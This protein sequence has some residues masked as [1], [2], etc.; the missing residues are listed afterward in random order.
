MCFVFL[1]S[2]FLSILNHTI[3]RSMLK[4]ARECDIVMCSARRVL[5]VYI[6]IS[7]ILHKLRFTNS[8]I[9]LYYMTTTTRL[10][11][12][13]YYILYILAI[14]NISLSLSKLVFSI[15]IFLRVY[16][17]LN[18]ACIGNIYETESSHLQFVYA[19]DCEFEHMCFFFHIFLS[20]CI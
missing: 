17:L 3:R 14:I 4:R 6:Y 11:M 10:Y 13:H 20:I 7:P 15:R 8:C 1:F 5:Y 19:Y 2:F 12:Q 9:I 16:I 18:T